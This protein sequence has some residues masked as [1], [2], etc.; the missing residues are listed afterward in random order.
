M[1]APVGRGGHAAKN[2]VALPVHGGWSSATLTVSK[3]SAVW[4]TAGIAMAA[5]CARFLLRKT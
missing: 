2:F 4:L 5:T 3:L 1:A